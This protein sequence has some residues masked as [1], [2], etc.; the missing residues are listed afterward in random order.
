MNKLIIPIF[1]VLVI[2]SSC[3]S[4]SEFCDC[5]EMS[6][7]NIDNLEKKRLGPTSGI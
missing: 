3:S 5:V 1:S 6:I 2:I 7:E 4:N